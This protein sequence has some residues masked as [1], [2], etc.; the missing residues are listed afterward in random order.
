MN[1]TLRS[2]IPGEEF[3]LSP[4]RGWTGVRGCLNVLEKR[5]VSLQGVVPR[6]V[7]RPACSFFPIQVELLHLKC[8]SKL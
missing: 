5:I 8:E 6:F 1:F 4:I 7:R 3:P 2:F